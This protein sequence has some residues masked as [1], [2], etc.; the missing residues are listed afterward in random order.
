MQLPYTAY[1]L[2][3]FHSFQ[4]QRA[5]QKLLVCYKICILQLF[6]G[7]YSFFF[8]PHPLNFLQKGL[9]SLVRSFLELK[10]E[11]LLF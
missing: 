2:A 1:L 4:M 11:A 6:L 10:G 7:F 9:C 8:S 3:K 5:E